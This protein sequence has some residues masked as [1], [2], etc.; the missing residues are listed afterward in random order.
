[1]FDVVT[2]PVLT[3]YR[4]LTERKIELVITRLVEFADR[5]DMV[6]E[7]LFDDDIVALRRNGAQDVIYNYLIFKEILSE[8]F[9]RLALRARARRLHQLL[10]RNAEQDRSL[11]GH[12]AA[13]Q[14]RPSR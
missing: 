14:A 8:A 7:T 1:M 3:L 13:L 6:V 2:G 9:A 11:D 4:D 12:E 10:Q 5:K